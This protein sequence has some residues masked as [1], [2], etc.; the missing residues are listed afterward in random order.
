MQI[1]VQE[2]I[3]NQNLAVA[4]TLTDLASTI[5][6]AVAGNEISNTLGGELVTGTHMR[7]LVAARMQLALTQRG[8]A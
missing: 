5:V 2:Q 7:Q 4:S 6:L 8:G 1:P 3:R